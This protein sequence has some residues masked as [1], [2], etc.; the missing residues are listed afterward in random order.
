LI[1]ILLVI[2]YTAVWHY[3]SDLPEK[4]RLR[5][6]QAFAWSL[7]ETG[8]YALFTY[9]FVHLD[10]GL[11]FINLIF[12]WGLGA[13]LEARIGSKSY[14]LCV[15]GGAAAAGLA[16]GVSMLHYHNLGPSAV[17]SGASGV[18]SG[19]IGASTVIYLFSRRG[20]P[21]P[22]FYPSL[23]IPRGYALAWLMLASAFLVLPLSGIIRPGG[24]VAGASF[25]C[26]AGGLG[27]GLWWGLV[28]GR[29]RASEPTGEPAHNDA[30]FSSNGLRALLKQYPTSPVVMV[31][32]A[33]A[34][35]NSGSRRQGEKYYRK[36]IHEL[37]RRGE[38]SF[39]AQVFE[40]FFLNYGKVF[41]GPI[42]IKLCR[43]LIE[44]GDYELSALAL[45]AFIRRA[46]VFPG[47]VKDRKLLPRAY[48]ILGRI[49]AEKLGDPHTARRVF[50]E[51]LRRYPHLE[52]RDMVRKKLRLL[53]MYGAR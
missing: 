37:W 5:T 21:L 7:G 51:F 52:Q 31:R 18:V 17:L 23:S 41:C 50:Q 20:S 4:E 16:H 42:Q 14:L 36:A 44:K 53:T 38:R 8:L 27:F 24:P 9:S 40:E 28:S 13:P 29:E 47:L 45:E 46:E 2:I 32:L 25:W 26:C 49:L 48:I 30:D 1:T 6:V 35:T 34:E 22:F 3:L 43:E 15:M 19:I 39:A 11:L 33:R 10:K 12:L